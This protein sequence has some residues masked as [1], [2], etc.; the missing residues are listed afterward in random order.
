M[1]RSTRGGGQRIKICRVTHRDTSEAKLYAASYPLGCGWGGATASC[2]TPVPFRISRFTLTHN[3]HIASALHRPGEGGREDGL[4]PLSSVTPRPEQ[5]QIQG[6]SFPPRLLIANRSYHLSKGVTNN[7][8]SGNPS[9]TSPSLVLLLL[10]L[11]MSPPAASFS[12]D[13]EV[14]A[15]GGHCEPGR[16]HVCVWPAAGRD[17]CPSPTESC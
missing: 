6:G 9:A 8:V 15:S 3:Y 14:Q 5:C 12:P 7:N 2:R 1:T 4:L 16:E 10:L 11:L 17:L 13:R